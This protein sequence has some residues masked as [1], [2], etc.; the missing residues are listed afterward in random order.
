[1]VLRFGDVE[2]TPAGL[3]WHLLHP[4]ETAEVVNVAPAVEIGYWASVR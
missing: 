1:L 4:I 2:T 3:R